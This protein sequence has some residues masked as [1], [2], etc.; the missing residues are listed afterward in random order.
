M[1]GN[2][3]NIIEQLE[4]NIPLKDENADSGVD[5]VEEEDSTPTSSKSPAW[6]DEDEQ[7]LRF[8]F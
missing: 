6:V 7:H 8:V 1:F 2:D 5:I 3:S 4:E